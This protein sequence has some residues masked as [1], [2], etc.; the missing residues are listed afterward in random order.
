MKWLSLLCC[1]FMSVTSWADTSF[2]TSCTDTTFS[3]WPQG[4]F[5][6]KQVLGS[7]RLTG[8][9]FTGFSIYD[10]DNNYRCAQVKKS[11]LDK[12]YTLNIDDEVASSCFI[13]NNSSLW[14]PAYS[15]HVT[16]YITLD[17]EEIAGSI[18]K[19]SSADYNAIF[20]FYYEEEPERFAYATLS[21]DTEELNFYSAQDTLLV[22][23]KLHFRPATY[24]AWGYRKS[25]TSSYWALT[26]CSDEPI[27]EAF[28][29]PFMAFISDYWW[30]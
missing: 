13:E 30:R 1:L 4:T 9:S 23:A 3:I 24:S 25:S 21:K 29:W 18:V 16:L 7:W 2:S 15:N 22:S 20:S 6:Y 12:L 8:R 10:E 28:F 27:D 11:H 19:E 26:K 14:S 17:Q 5:Y